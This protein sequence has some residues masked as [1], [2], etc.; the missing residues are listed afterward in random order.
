MSC[1]KSVPRAGGDE[2][3]VFASYKSA[4]LPFPAQAG[5]N[6]LSDDNHQLGIPVPRAGGDEPATNGKMMRIYEPFPA[7]AGM[8]R[9]SP[10]LLPLLLLRSPRRRG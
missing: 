1:F 3:S 8:N 2:P 4:S 10:L 9:V 6:R 7:Q 5:M